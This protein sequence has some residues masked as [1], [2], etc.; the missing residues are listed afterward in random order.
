MIVK[1]GILL[2]SAVFAVFLIIPSI[3]ALSCSF[4]ALPNDLPGKYVAD[5][6]V[7][8]EELI[9]NDDGTFVQRVHLKK[10]NK[11][12]ISK[13][14]W[15]HDTQSGYITFHGNFMIVL[16]GFR[17]FNPE[18]DHPP[19]GLVVVPVYKYWGCIRIGTS[20]GILYKKARSP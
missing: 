4:K 14:K 8:E 18:Y 6:P 16:D 10:T 19:P 20:E 11:V 9:I 13:G 1:T 2:L 12:N 3:H 15:T 7:A 17:E 5:Y